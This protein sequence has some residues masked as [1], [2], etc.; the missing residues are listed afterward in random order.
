MTVRPIVIYGTPVLHAPTETVTEPVSELQE[1]IAD[2]YE[3]M[4]V[5]RG[6]GLAAN[7]IGVNKRIFVFDCPDD[8]GVYHRG[9]FINPVLETSDIPLGMPETDGSDDEGCLSLPGL[10]FP[11]GRAS[12]AKV[13]GLN[14]QGEEVSMEATGFLARC[15]QHE[16]GH[17]DG[18][19]YA[20]VLVGRWK[21][22][23]KKAIKAEGWGA[24]GSTWMPGED[25]DP[26]GHDDLDEECDEN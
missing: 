23:A 19:V 25:V 5:A 7:Q 8:Q 4:A 22:A 24:P 1:L 9:C 11:T 13:T 21:R 26:F 2:M 14:E 6:V 3:T 20:D 18:F 10:G 12:W 17:L 15:F 16:V